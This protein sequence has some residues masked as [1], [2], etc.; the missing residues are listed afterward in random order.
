IG[1]RI[2]TV[3]LTIGLAGALYAGLYALTQQ[4][5]MALDSPHLAYRREVRQ[6]LE[7]KREALIARLRQ[8]RPD[9]SDEEI[10]RLVERMPIEATPEEIPRKFPLKPILAALYCLGA[11]GSLFRVPGPGPRGPPRT[12]K[13]Q[14][15]FPVLA[16]AAAL[17]G[18]LALSG[19]WIWRMG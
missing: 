19:G 11:L 15:I 10:R 18:T 3:L 1:V 16:C 14:E 9:L 5:S 6:L 4:R 17:L 13:P 12:L 7:K 2:G 8:N